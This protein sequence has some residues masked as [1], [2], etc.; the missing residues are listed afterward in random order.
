ML[1]VGDAAAEPLYERLLR[2][3]HATSWSRGWREVQA[4]LRAEPPPAL[5]VVAPPLDD[6]S[7]EQLLERLGPTSGPP[8][9]V[10][11]PAEHVDPAS[12][13]YAGAF[14]CVID[15]ERQPQRFLGAVGY[16]LGAREDDR[17]RS[18]L[19][20]RE[21]DAA[22]LDELVGGHPAM[23]RVFDFV[24]QVCRRTA[25]GRTPA[26]LLTGETGTGK[27]AI[28]RALHFQSVRRHRPF[29]QINCAAIPANLVE[30]ELFGHE[31]GAFT[32]AR[33]GRPGLFETADGG[34]LFLDELPSLP[35][36]LQAKL[37]TVI[38][39]RAVRRVGGRTLR[40]VDVQLVAA[41][42]PVLKRMVRKG[43]FREDLYHRLNV[44][45]IGLPPLRERGDDALELAEQ[46]VR[47]LCGEYG[48]PVMPLADSARD[49]IRRYYWPGNVRELRN[50]IERIVLLSEGQAIEGWQFERASGEILR[51]DPAEEDPSGFRIQL[52][53]QGFALDELEREVIRHALERHEGNV[54]QTAR[55]LHIS[56]QTLIY[57]MKKHELR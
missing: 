51:V 18:V 55:Y 56:R 57:R 44:L 45:S 12:L 30:A 5:V 50:Q 22:R 33:E 48:V 15:P 28:A 34:T 52:P 29:V 16:A 23:Q 26:I 42:Q 32:G 35:L 37:L 8:V 9:V 40:P 27:G 39:N 4:E 49:F 2:R 14:E 21:A 7:P 6:G 24:R 25:R 17:Q 13:M 41:S 38:E 36:D 47:E 43:G 31:R 19:R 54:S 1:L 53:P 46:F 20:D 11:G 3:G 10:A